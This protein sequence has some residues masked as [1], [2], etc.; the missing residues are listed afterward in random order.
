ML[1]PE[2]RA[3]LE[4]QVE[5]ALAKRSIPGALVY[6]LVTLVVALST[7]YYSDHSVILSTT[8][9]IVLAAGITRMVAAR[10]I[11]A[12]APGNTKKL[13]RFFLASLYVIAIVWGAFCA[14]TI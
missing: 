6:F 11:L 8:A 2:V 1:M 3:E 5:R 9:I 10:R 14:A 12:A 4:N 13:R 7:P